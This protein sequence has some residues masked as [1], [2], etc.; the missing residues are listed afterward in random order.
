MDLGIIAAVIMLVV[1]AIVTFTTEAPGYIHL[2][3]TIGFFVLIW[4]ISARGSAPTPKR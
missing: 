1:W 4:R 2:L 3:L